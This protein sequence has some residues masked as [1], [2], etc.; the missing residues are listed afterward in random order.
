[1]INC[2][3][4]WRPLGEL[5]SVTDFIQSDNCGIVAEAD[6]LRGVIENSTIEN[7]A[8]FVR[9][10]FKYPFNKK[11]EPCASGQEKYHQVS[12]CKWLTS[13]YAPYQWNYPNVVLKLKRGIC[14]DTAN[15]FTSLCAA[16]GF[17]DAYTV[18]GEV[19]TPNLNKLIGYHAWGEKIYKGEPCS[20]ETTVEEP[21]NI[22]FPGKDTYDRCS[23][24]A[25]KRGI[26]YIPQSKYNKKG[27]IDN[28]GPL[29][30]QLGVIMMELIG[31]PAG[32]ANRDLHRAR[33]MA[34]LLLP[35]SPF[36]P[37]NPKKVEAERRKEEKV[38]QSL[39]RGA[40][41]V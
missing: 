10:E 11:G 40:Y 2:P 9:D 31:L 32:M 19:R 39:I 21:V 3:V 24:W 12:W 41:H 27:Y 29:G 33:V 22:I 6:R 16:S 25:S 36:E 7:I 15:L 1:M 26:Y 28:L 30:H 17:D 34:G 35:F 23:D 18:L 5:C 37:V 38:L 20:V 14:I 13:V 4:P 8:A